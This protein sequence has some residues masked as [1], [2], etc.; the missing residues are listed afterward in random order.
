M[1]GRPPV[2]FFDVDG[3]LV[4]RDGSVEDGDAGVKET[5]A[6]TPRVSDAIRRFRERGGLPV[7]CTGRPMPTVG[8]P[9]LDLPWSALVTMAGGHVEVAGEVV[10]DVTI[11]DDLMRRCIG[12]LLECGMPALLEGNAT[13][14]ALVPEGYGPTVFDGPPCASTLEGVLEIDPDLAFG[15]IVFYSEHLG[16]LERYRHF[17]YGNFTVFDI[18]VG[19]HEMTLPT[20]SKR[21]GIGAVLEKLG[22]DYGTTYAFGDSENDLPMLEAVD[23]PV[24]MGNA[25]DRVKRRA[26]YVTGDVRDDGVASALEHFGLI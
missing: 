19:M 13:T 1:D 20:I 17:V 14:C 16:R 18:A 26:C 4:W 15:K 12:V 23:R 3:T 9:I 10:F 22:D 25:L 24:V 5:C 7:L 8:R 6:P 2:A 21:R 11:P